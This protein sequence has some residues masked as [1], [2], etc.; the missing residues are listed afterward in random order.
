ML[1]ILIGLGLAATSPLQEAI[2]EYR[3]HDALLV[4]Q[5]EAT[6]PSERM[7]VLGLR[8]DRDQ[9]VRATLRDLASDR[10]WMN[11]NPMV[12]AELA[13]AMRSLDIENTAWL[14]ADM[15]EHGW[16][17][18]SDHGED[19]A[20]DAFLI[21]QH[22]THDTDFMQ[23]MV[24]PFN[25]MR[26][27]GDVDPRDYA[28]LFDR[29]AVLTGSAQ[30]YGTQ[31]GCANGNRIQMGPIEDEANVDARRAELGLEPLSVAL[32]NLAC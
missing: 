9:L 29:V 8:A 2:A 32:E 11:A 7:A 3:E 20:E 1:S 4:E 10:E 23:S 6:D 12:V 5:L 31:W 19:A 27:S 16:V 17:T 24:A 21:L 13:G 18:I 28:L 30:R 25:D 26:L 14:K 15:S 22:S